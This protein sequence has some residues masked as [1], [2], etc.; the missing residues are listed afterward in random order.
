MKRIMGLIRNLFKQPL[1]LGN[2]K[3]CNHPEDN[4][5]KFDYRYSGYDF[6]WE[7]SCSALGT[8]YF[9]NHR[10]RCQCSKFIVLDNLTYLEYKSKV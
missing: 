7:L 3:G 9:D 10:N 6:G 4:H 2:C 5:R 1:I 8:K